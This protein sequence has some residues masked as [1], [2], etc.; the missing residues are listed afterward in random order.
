[1]S[2]LIR[3]GDSDL[4][5]AARIGGADPVAFAVHGDRAGPPRASQ[6]ICIHASFAGHSFAGWILTHMATRYP[7]RIDK[8]IYLDAAFDVRASDSIVARRPA[9]R[10]A[11]VDVQTK[12]DVIRWLRRDFFGMWSPAL[13]A[14]YRNRS[15][16]EDARGVLLAPIVADAMRAPE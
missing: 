15:V 16:D 3:V 11:L 7:S 8:L 9:K 10:P 1:M 14:E 2:R 12:D 6:P 4:I 5:P 13:E